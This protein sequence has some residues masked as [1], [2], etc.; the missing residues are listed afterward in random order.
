MAH[1]LDLVL[2]CY[3]PQPGWAER[4][5]EAYAT[6]ARALPEAPG[7]IVVNDGSAFGVTAGDRERLRE[8]VPALRWLANDRN[9]GKGHTLR[10]GVQAADAEWV[11]YTDIDF[12]YTEESLLAVYRTLEAGADVAAG[13]KDADYYRGVPWL[14]RVVSRWLRRLVKALL[15]LPIADTQCGLKGFNR[16]GREAFLATTIDRYL[17]DLEFLHAAFRRYGLDV[18]AVPA[19]LKPGIVFSRMNPRILLTEGV[20]FLRV[21]WR[22]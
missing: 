10:R 1:R 7:L 19:E 15:R 6:V 21:W 2:P 22:R 3:N 20:N 8:A 13:V 11:I 16:R 4:V 5:A 17:F 18:R 9:R 14:R 12:P